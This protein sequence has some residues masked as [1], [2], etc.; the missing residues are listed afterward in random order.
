MPLL[1][2]RPDDLRGLARPVAFFPMLASLFFF[3]VAKMGLLTRLGNTPI[4][5]GGQSP[6]RRPRSLAG[7]SPEARPEVQRS[8]FKVGRDI[9]ERTGH[10]GTFRQILSNLRD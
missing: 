9:K 1:A 5:S 4:G 6:T 8:R 3:V 10:A 2:I 7:M